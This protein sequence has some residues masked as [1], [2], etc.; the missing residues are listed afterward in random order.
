L[1]L[2]AQEAEDYLHWV[3]QELPAEHSQLQPVTFCLVLS[4]EALAELQQTQTL[5][6]LLVRMDFNKLKIYFII[7][8]E[9]VE[10]LEVLVQLAQLHQLEEMEV[11]EDMVVVV[12]VVEADLQEQPLPEAE[13]VAT[14]S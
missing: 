1:L 13:M 11:L 9:L 4:Q 6:E 12:E 3:Q 5:Q 7:T 2:E 8:E 10:V 14:E